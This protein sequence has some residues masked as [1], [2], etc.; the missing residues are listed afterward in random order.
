MS[1]NLRTMSKR[2]CERFNKHIRSVIV[3]SGCVVL[4]SLFNRVNGMEEC[5]TVSIIDDAIRRGDEAIKGAWPFAAV[6]SKRSDNKVLCGGT[7]IS[8]K[9]V[10]TGKKMMFCSFTNID[11]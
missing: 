7:L 10:L 11:D 8:K 9:H 2:H 6:L 1:E 5:G 4:V 3:F